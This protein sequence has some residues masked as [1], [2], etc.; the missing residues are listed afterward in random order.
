MLP[1]QPSPMRKK[2]D[3]SVTHYRFHHAYFPPE[4]LQTQSLLFPCKPYGS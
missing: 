4:Y 1:V 2:A 3:K